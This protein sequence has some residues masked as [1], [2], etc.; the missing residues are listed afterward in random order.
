M[1]IRIRLHNP[2]S[3]LIWAGI[4][5]QVLLILMKL[6][7]YTEASWAKVLIPTEA[8]LVMAVM[9]LAALLLLKK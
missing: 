4:G 5:V 8:A 6:V 1:T 9:F 7:G 3:C 2:M